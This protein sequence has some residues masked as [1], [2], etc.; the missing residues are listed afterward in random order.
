MVQ[1]LL[2][3]PVSRAQKEP[4][5]LAAAAGRAMGSSALPAPALT[6]NWGEK[7]CIKIQENFYSVSIWFDSWFNFFVLTQHSLS[8]FCIRYSRRAD[9]LVFLYYYSWFQQPPSLGAEE[10]CWW[11]VCGGYAAGT[12]LVSDLERK[13]VELLVRFHG[14]WKCIQPAT[15]CP[16]MGKSVYRGVW[17]KN[18]QDVK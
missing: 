17:N 10:E 13:G 7:L 12:W 15:L 2:L 8:E 16:A 5:E 1:C 6:D 11:C 9:D 4:L 3:C 18:E 14:R